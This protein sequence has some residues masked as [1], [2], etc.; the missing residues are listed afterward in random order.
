MKIKTK[1]NKSPLEYKEIKGKHDKR[2]D[3]RDG[4]HNCNWACME[5]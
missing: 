4:E 5:E 3:E 2:K 1:T